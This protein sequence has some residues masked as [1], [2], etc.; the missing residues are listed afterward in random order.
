MSVCLGRV[1]SVRCVV[2]VC[3]GG[4]EGGLKSGM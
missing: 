3:E 4:R 2:C 1:M